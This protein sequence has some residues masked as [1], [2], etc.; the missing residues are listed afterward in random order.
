MSRFKTLLL[1]LLPPLLPRP[2]S[3]AAPLP[4]T[5][6]QL[7]T[8]DDVLAGAPLVDGH[9]DFPI[10]IRAFYHNHIYGRNFSDALPLAGQVDFP[11][12]REGRLG[13]QF[14]S[15]YVEC[16]AGD[17]DDGATPLLET[18]QQIDLMRR[19]VD[20]F[21]TQ[22]RW[23][24][25]ASDVWAQW[26]S[27]PRAGVASLMGVEGLHQVGGSP[28]A[29]LRLFHALGVRYATLAHVCHN[30][31]ADSAAPALPRHGGLSPAGRAVVREMNRIGLIVD[32]SHVSA[33]TAR[34]A[35]RLSR[36][37]VLFSHSSAAAL[38]PIPRNVPDDVLHAL[39][40]NDGVVMVNF[41]P[42]FV[43][44]AANATLADVADHI[45]Y[46]GELIGYRHVGLGADFDGM[47]F[48]AGPVGLEH[49]GKYPALLAELLRRGVGLHHV[50]GVAGANVLRVLAAVEEV[51]AKMAS[52]EPLE[53]DVEPMVASW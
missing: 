15:V 51:A 37:P 40:A 25:S 33:D 49:V 12:L 29:A 2:V 48:D 24:R 13:A 42:P 22:L 46:I 10:Y 23:A 11:R 53:D 5:P 14:W 41:Y 39:R 3:G 35:L 7:P 20:H 17:G 27:G 47:G 28:A 43:A 45:V 30:A 38:C 44:C 19:L 52:V 18:V 1:L 8:V 4:A 16:P 6:L 36:A 50:R 31:F 26:R 34:Q 32:L 21:P 9:N